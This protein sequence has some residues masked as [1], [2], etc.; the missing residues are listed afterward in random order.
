[1]VIGSWLSF[2]GTDLS[3]VGGSLSTLNL[4][5]RGFARDASH[6]GLLASRRTSIFPMRFHAEWCSFQVVEEQRCRWNGAE[7]QSKIQG[8]ATPAVS[9]SEI[10][11]DVS[12]RSITSKFSLRDSGEIEPSL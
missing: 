2:I 9:P 3:L 7:K 1:M 4:G 10:I 5:P 12:V 11:G 6:P 8:T